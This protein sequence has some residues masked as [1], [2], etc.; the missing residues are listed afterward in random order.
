MHV[1]KNSL[2]IDA[3]FNQH[4]NKWIKHNLYNDYALCQ[5]KHGWKRD[6]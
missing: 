3:R 2:E 6:S 5:I 4:V 1:N